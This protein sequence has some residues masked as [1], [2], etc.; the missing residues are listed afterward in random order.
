MALVYA[1]LGSNLGDKKFIIE[2]AIERI[3]DIFGYCCRSEFVESE[4]WG[5]ESANSFCNIGI[6]FRSEKE[7][8]EILDILQGIERELSDVSHR[9][10]YGNYQDREI[11]I[12]IMAIDELKF[13]SERLTIPHPHLH[14][15]EFFL[16]PYN[17]LRPLS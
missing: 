14:D 2:I 7:P 15:R 11:D 17:E 6:S 16:K 5:F 4:P 3:S 10:K 12:D 8:E 1:N 13:V 9:D